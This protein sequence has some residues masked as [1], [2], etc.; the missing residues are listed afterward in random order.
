MADRFFPDKQIQNAPV[1]RPVRARIFAWMIVIAVAGTLVSSGF[2]ISAR[3]HFKAVELGY[4]NEDLRREAIQLEEKKR[5]LELER[6]RA[7]LPPEIERRARN[8]GLER[9]GK[10]TAQNRPRADSKR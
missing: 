2:I 9:A 10:A 8:L 3:K 1:A 4:Q 5:Q 6:A 7:L